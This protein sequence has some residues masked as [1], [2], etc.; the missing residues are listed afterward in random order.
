[1]QHAGLPPGLLGKNGDVMPFTLKELATG[2]GKRGRAL[3]LHIE[4]AWVWI[5]LPSYH[6]LWP[7]IPTPCDSS[8]VSA[9]WGRPWCLL[10][11]PRVVSGVGLRWSMK[12]RGM[13]PGTQPALCKHQLLLLS[14]QEDL[15]KQ[16]A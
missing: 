3:E 7:V 5:S 4:T 15:E 6:I 10:P 14:R 2:W 13:V 11:S 8:S 12:A 1:M 16:L 9:T